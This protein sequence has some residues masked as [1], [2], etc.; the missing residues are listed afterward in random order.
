MSPGLMSDEPVSLGGIKF[1]VYKM[2]RVCTTAF[3]RRTKD[4][5]VIPYL[6]LKVVSLS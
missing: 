4:D 1:T 2:L 3:P 6:S 5:Y